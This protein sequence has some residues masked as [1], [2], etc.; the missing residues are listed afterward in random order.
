MK[1]FRPLLLF[2]VCLSITGMAHAGALEMLRGIKQ[3]SD[4][5]GA[6]DSFQSIRTVQGM[7]N[8]QPIFTKAKRIYIKADLAPMQG[9]A[10]RMNRLVEKVLCDNINRIID[11]LKDYDMKGATPK[12]KTGGP[13]KT[14]KKKIV[15]ML[16]TQDTSKDGISITVKYVD[17]NTNETLKSLTINAADDYL[18]A[19][20]DIVDDLHGDFVISSRT[21]NPYTLKKWPKRFKKYSKKKKH[22]NVKMKRKERK[23]LAANLAG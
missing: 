17:Q 10:A 4:A 14:S 8:A 13:K 18:V 7:E 19:V 20:E 6:Y 21:N 2:V 15:L 22:R 1:L 23:Q 16:V 5:K 11:N 9:D 3:A 12:C